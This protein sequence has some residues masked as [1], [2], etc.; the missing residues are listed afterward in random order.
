VEHYT[1]LRRDAIKAYLN[2]AKNRG[3][4]FSHEMPLL[5]KEEKGKAGPLWE[6]NMKYLD[7]MNDLCEKA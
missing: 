2:D 4:Q 1:L 3:V 6:A 5:I 7:V